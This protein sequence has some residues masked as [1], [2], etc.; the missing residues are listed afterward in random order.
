MASRNLIELK[1]KSTDC[2]TTPFDLPIDHALSNP[3]DPIRRRGEREK[4]QD[5]NQE[6]GRG[7]KSG[8]N[9][10]T[11]ENQLNANWPNG[12]GSMAVKGDHGGVQGKKSMKERILIENIIAARTRTET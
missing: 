11:L 6:N 2:Q 8:A 12:G 10:S 1:R 9:D 5:K 4:W 3:S 7:W